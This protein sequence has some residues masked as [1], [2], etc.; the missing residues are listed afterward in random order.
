MS[1]AYF[2]SIEQVEEELAKAHYI[3]DRALATVIF[4]AHRL[5]KPLFLEGEPGVGKTEVGIIMAKLSDTELIRLQC[6]EGL[7]AST[8]LYEWNYPKQLLHIRLEEQERK[9]KEEIE[10]RIY[11]SEFLIKRPLLQAILSS[12]ERPPVL[13]IDEVDRSDEEFEAFLLEIL[14]DFQITIPE[15]GTLKARKRPMVVVTSNRTRD[16]H[17]ALKRRCLYHWIEYPSFEKE[18]RI[19]ATRIPQIEEHLAKQ[20]A[21]F[22]RKI[23]TVNFLKKPG[24]SETLDWANALI[25]MEKKHLDE[26]VV[27]ET[28]GC[29]LKYQEDIKRFTEEIWG[30]GARRS[31]FL[32]GVEWDG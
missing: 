7:D 18:Y 23:R 11:G 32:E 4:L 9:G 15:I 31:E 13:L 19:V 29:I 5:Q 28:L 17:D 8:A 6:Y 25:T 20:V 14:S 2:D 24:I 12:N 27:S 3:A 26:Q 10:R 16:V 30:D 22:M 1:E 21:H